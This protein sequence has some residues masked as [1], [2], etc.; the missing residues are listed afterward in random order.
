M[1]KLQ[2]VY[3]GKIDIGTVDI[4]WL[5]YADTELFHHHFGD[6]MCGC[7]QC[8]ECLP[9]VEYMIWWSVGIWLNE[10]TTNQR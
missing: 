8:E 2:D 3:S 4:D 5:H 6:S 7:G 9:P 10:K 1:P